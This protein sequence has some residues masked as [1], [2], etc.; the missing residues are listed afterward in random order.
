[1]ISVIIPSY[2]AAAYLKEAIDSLLLERQQGI[3]LEVIVC[4]DCSTDDSVAIA[5]SYGDAVRT[6]AAERNR[7]AAGTRNVGVNVSRGELLAL[8][9]SDDVSLPG[10][11]S[12]S[13]QGLDR[14][15]SDMVFSDVPIL[16]DEKGKTWLEIVGSKE[17]IVSNCTDGTIR[18]PLSL[19]CEH[20]NFILPSTILIRREVFNDVGLFNDKI[21]S[22]D[23]FEF[24]ARVAAAGKRISFIDQPLALRRVHGSNLSQNWRKR[25]TS[26][27]LTIDSIK[28]L[29]PTTD[30]SKKALDKWGAQLHRQMAASDLEQ[31]DFEGMRSHLRASLSLQVSPKCLL[32]LAGSFLAPELLYS[33]RKKQAR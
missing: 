17:V 28:S 13:L 15:K 1:M 29:P 4:D 3:D 10:R 19:L 26:E 25:F 31:R 30:A 33:I 12:A 21:L 22:A 7:G 14:F 9:D 11:F 32:Y 20:G 2:N 24:F 5:R 27:L 18:D 8:L 16:G 6:I 23:D